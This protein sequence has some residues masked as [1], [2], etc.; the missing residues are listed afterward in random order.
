VTIEEISCYELAYQI[1]RYLDTRKIDEPQFSESISIPCN[2]LTRFLECQ[3]ANLSISQISK[4]CDVLCISMD[5]LVRGPVEESSFRVLVKKCVFA[6]KLKG[7]VLYPAYIS[8]L[9]RW[10]EKNISASCLE[11]YTQWFIYL[12]SKNDISYH[13]IVG[14]PQILPSAVCFTRRI[15]KK[16]AEKLKRLIDDYWKKNKDKPETP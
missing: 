9:K 4:I 12:S 8:F 13:S 3:G 5:L 15:S 11:R 14:A 2:E 1:R 10:Q 7:T 16:K 6:E